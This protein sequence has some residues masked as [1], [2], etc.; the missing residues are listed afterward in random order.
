MPYCNDMDKGLNV[1]LC[2]SKQTTSRSFFTRKFTKLLK[3]EKQ[4]NVKTCASSDVNNWENIDFKQAKIYVKKL[5]MRIVKAQKE[6]KYGKVKSLQW[7]LTHSFYAKALAIKRVTENKGKNTAGVD[8]ELWLTP[9]SKFKA[10]KKLKRNGY[11]PQP[12]RRVYI[13]KSNGKMRPLSIPTMTDRA[14][15]AL[16]KLALE[17]VAETTADINSYGFRPERSAHDAISQCFILLG[18]PSGAKWVLEG[19][20]KG[21]FD[22][23]SHEWILNNIPMD[24]E[25]LNKFLKSGFIE[26]GRLFPTEQGT[27]QGGVISPV[28]CNMV[29][30]GIEKILKAKFYTTTRNHKSY[31]P[32]VNF[33]RY[34][35]DFIIT[36]ESKEILEEKVLPIV[37]EFMIE[38]GLTLSEEKTVITHIDDGFDF[39][40]FN[41]RKY[42]GKLLIKPSKKNIKSFLD[43]IRKIVEENPTIKQETLIQMLNPIIRGWTEYHKYTVSKVAFSKVDHEIFLILWRWI[44]RRHPKKGKHWMVKKYFHTV[45]NRL[46][47]FSV[48]RKDKAFN[49]NEQMYTRLLCAAD[50]KITRFVKVKSEANPYDEEW[51]TYFEERKTD[52]MLRSLKGRRILTYLFKSQKGICPICSEKITVETDFKVHEITENNRTVKFMLHP[53]CHRKLHLNEKSVNVPAIVK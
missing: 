23:I 14:M 35:D 52:K 30:D 15:Q 49:G 47:T 19:D 48:L 22:N 26:T 4:M 18:I 37:K 27:P 13:P 33:V 45:G 2:E 6:K 36:G 32:K 29:L 50:T 43:K 7:I 10:I 21:C 20:I 17:P 9:E 42:N 46:W 3:G 51:Q 16:Y 40:G 8:N 53:E 34:A 5:Q 24:K 44:K 38:R 12:L 28:I 41:V 25:I 1:T 11:N 31:S 39:L